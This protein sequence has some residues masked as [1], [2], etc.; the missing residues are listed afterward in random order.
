MLLNACEWSSQCVSWFYD[1]LNCHFKWNDEREQKKN[2]N[3][4]TRKW[5]MT[6]G[7]GM[8]MWF[9]WHVI[10]S[11]NTGDSMSDFIL[12][13]CKI[14]FCIFQSAFTFE[15]KNHRFR[16]DSFPFFQYFWSEISIYFRKYTIIG[17]NGKKWIQL[18]EW[19]AIS[20]QFSK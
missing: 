7:N 9:V 2:C 10:L 15:K 6:F 4:K 19:D 8:E 17:R 11:M 3:N 1:A 5:E 20:E 12:F 18:D 16:W 13:Y 14:F